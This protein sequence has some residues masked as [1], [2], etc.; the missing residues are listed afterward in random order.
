MEK[1]AKGMKTWKKGAIVGGIWGSIL[2]NLVY[3]LVG[4]FFWGT[5]LGESAPQAIIKES[6][7]GEEL[8]KLFRLKTLS[9]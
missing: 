4:L 9:L 6:S 2:G 3:Y 8:R 5:T 7:E 1:A